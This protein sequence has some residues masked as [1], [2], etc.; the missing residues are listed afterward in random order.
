ML[1]FE[2][3]THTYTLD[4]EEIPSVTEILRFAHH[5]VYPNADKAIMDLAADKGT[6]VH[7]ACEELDLKGT[8]ETDLDIE[9]YV[10]AYIEFRKQHSV[11]WTAIEYPIWASNEYGK[12][13]GT[14]DRFGFLDGN[15]VLLDIKTTSTISKKHQLLYAAQLSA[16]KY[17]LMEAEAKVPKN[18]AI[19]QLKNDGSYKLIYVEQ[20]LE[21][22]E[23][24]CFMHYLFDSV[25][26][27]RRKGK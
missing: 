22:F 15:D 24:C 27:K 9:G 17:A 19:L 18:L 5:E 3:T 26:R 2:P 12:Y 1:E 25:K 23:S 16:Y 7:A 10:K 6:R 8:T 21:L 4:G 14:L 13:A 20:E 11:H